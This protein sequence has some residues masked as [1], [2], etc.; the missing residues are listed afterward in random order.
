LNKKII[1][2][3][4]PLLMSHINSALMSI[5]NQYTKQFVDKISELERE[6]A[7]LKQNASSFSLGLKTDFDR[8][9]ERHAELKSSYAEIERENTQLRQDMEKLI[10]QQNALE[11]DVSKHFE[12]V[13]S[14]IHPQKVS[15]QYQTPKKLSTVEIP[16]VVPSQKPVH[17]EAKATTKL[18]NTKYESDSELDSS[19]DDMP[20]LVSSSE[21]EQEKI[22]P[23]KLR[24]AN[25]PAQNLDKSFIGS[26]VS[27]GT[28]TTNLNNIN[29]SSV[30]PNDVESEDDVNDYESIL[31]HVITEGLMS[32]LEN[33]NRSP[34]ANKSKGT[35]KNFASKL[36]SR[37]SH[38]SRIHVPVK[39]QKNHNHQK[40]QCQQN[41][42]NLNNVT[43]QNVGNPF[44]FMFSPH[45]NNQ[46]AQTK[47]N[48]N[49]GQ[50]FLNPSTQEVQ[51]VQKILESLF[52]PTK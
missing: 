51:L 22:S 36:E 18:L 3:I 46:Q 49:P 44:R 52:N 13:F 45:S 20:D 19:D 30:L 26:N 9:T 29:L 50:N 17:R 6:N 24:F 16:Q 38:R 43:E 1:I 8:L 47:S 15:Q 37:P 48:A 34:H 35:E 32:G 23:R 4:E 10:M 5:I 21:D 28:N 40:H 33:M 2:T 14:G 7:Q 31:K 42:T 11:S 39:K 12:Q 27:P 25:E 41:Q